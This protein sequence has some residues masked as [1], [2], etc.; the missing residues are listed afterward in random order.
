MNGLYRPVSMKARYSFAMSTPQIVST[1]VTAQGRAELPLFT[2]DGGRASMTLG[3]TEAENYAEW[4]SV[5][6][7]PTRVR[8]L[9]T[10]STSPT[11]AMRVGDLAAALGVSQST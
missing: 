8:L 10:L 1:P 5:L 4:F 6:A 7:D 9:H 3:K 11:S 2:P